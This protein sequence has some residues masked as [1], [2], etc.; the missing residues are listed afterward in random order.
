MYAINELAEIDFSYIRTINLNRVDLKIESD[1]PDANLNFVEFADIYARFIDKEE[2]NF[3]KNDFSE[4]TA[5]I[6]EEEKNEE[7]E[8]NYWDL[9]TSNLSLIMSY[10]KSENVGRSI[11]PTIHLKEYKDIL[12]EKQYVLLFLKVKIDKAPSYD[13]TIKGEMD[14]RI[15]IDLQKSTKGINYLKKRLINYPTLK[16]RA[17]TIFLPTTKKEITLVFLRDLQYRENFQFLLLQGRW[18]SSF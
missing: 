3:L 18:F 6:V 13:F 10:Q 2:Y 5:D 11:S 8:I 12:K 4:C 7:A 1:D 15:D 14:L 16:S 17:P 9:D